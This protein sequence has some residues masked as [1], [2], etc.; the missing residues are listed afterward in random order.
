M[1]FR[2]RR[3][4]R[5]GPFYITIDQSGRRSYGVKL[6]R[7]SHNFTHRTT[8]IDTPGPGGLVHRN[9]RRRRR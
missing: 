9:G 1:R 7:F 3:A 2:A 6:G 5:F 8:H 4:F